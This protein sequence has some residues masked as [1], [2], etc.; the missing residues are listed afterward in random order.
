MPASPSCL[1]E[2]RAATRRSR[3]PRDRPVTWSNTASLPMGNNTGPPRRRRRRG[4]LARLPDPPWAGTCSRR[5][6]LRVG[7]WRDTGDH[8][9]ERLR[10]VDADPVIGGSRK[11]PRS[12]TVRIMGATP[13]LVPGRP[14]PAQVRLS[15]PSRYPRTR[16]AKLWKSVAEPLRHMDGRA[17]TRALPVMLG[18]GGHRTSAGSTTALPGSA[19]DSIQRIA[20]ARA[21]VAAPQ[22]LICDEPTSALDVSVQAQILQPPARAAARDR[23]HLRLRDPTTWRWPRSWPTT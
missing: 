22:V 12:G 8:R 4:R 15:R 11:S 18:E 1:P 10:Q 20:I 17:K 3:R 2:R 21:L 16:T 23:V 14:G 6:Q 7:S 19:G 5:R 13:R 9:R